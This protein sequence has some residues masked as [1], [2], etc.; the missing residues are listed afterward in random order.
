MKI[1]FKILVLTIIIINVI[2]F[3]NFDMDERKG[4]KYSFTLANIEALANESSDSNWISCYETISSE[5][6]NY[7]THITYC[8][9]CTAKLARSWSQ[10]DSCK[11]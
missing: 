7:Q 5:G 8:G 11:K 9:E 3:V 4:R 2:I 6:T 1:K 10:L